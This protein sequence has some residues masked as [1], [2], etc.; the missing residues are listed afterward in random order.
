MSDECIK[1]AFVI[2]IAGVCDRYRPFRE[3]IIGIGSRE[4]FITPAAACFI[5]WHAN[6]KMAA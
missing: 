6:R 3:G 5:Y 4:M 1:S 2:A